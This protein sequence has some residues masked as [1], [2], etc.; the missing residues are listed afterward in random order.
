MKKN[1]FLLILLA[2][3]LNFAQNTFPTNGNVGIG[4]TAPVAK[5]DIR[6]NGTDGLVA[7]FG[8]DVISADIGRK[9]FIEFRDRD[10]DAYPDIL[11][12]YARL[13]TITEGAWGE[14]KSIYFE[15]GG[16]ERFRIK[17]NGSIGIGTINPLQKLDVNGGI[18][19]NTGA[20]GGLYAGENTSHPRKVFGVDAI[21]S[22]FSY[23]Q[24]PDS[25]ADDGIQFKNSNGIALAT[26]LE[27]GNVGIGTTNPKFK[28]EVSSGAKIKTTTIGATMMSAENGWI[29]DGWLTG[30][31]GPAVWDQTISKWVRPS[32]TYN[33][34]GGIVFQDEGTYFIFDKAGT[35]LEYT[36]TEFLNKAYMYANILNGNV[37]IGT[38]IPDTKLTVNG[39]V[40][41]KEVKIDLNISA[42]DYVFA[43]EYKLKSLEEVEDYIKENSHLP[44]IPSAEEI[45]K[46]GLML[47]EMNMSLLKKI[48]ELTLYAIEQQK[49]NKEQQE[50][51]NQLTNRSKKIEQLEKDFASLR[52]SL[53]LEK[54]KKY[55]K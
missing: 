7:I 42:P 37:G 27:G 21:G 2:V 12:R 51:I 48:E 29:R 6:R 28:L 30:C 36:N 52:D 45:E 24:S 46:K 55:E 11:T 53:T 31:Y 19:F 18:R 15:T 14:N 13:G 41:A 23:I 4:T 44:E 54:D 35:Q 50:Q 5:L 16:N 34:I 49:Q 17:Y 20:S 1:V 32:G 33:D 26:I 3:Q 9:N 43:K 39:T 25:D 22:Q 8:S 10:T 40:H 47:A 38:I